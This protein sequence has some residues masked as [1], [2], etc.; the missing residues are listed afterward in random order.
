MS[1]R[2]VIGLAGGMCSGKDS[3]ADFFQQEFGYDHRSTSDVARAYIRDKDLGEPTRDLTREVATQLRATH[4]TEYLLRQ[5]I[6]AADSQRII[7]SGIY[8]V[9]EAMYLK[10]VGG[11]IV[12]I[13]ADDKLRF[14]R[15]AKRAR[16]GELPELE[17][18]RRLMDN[19]LNSQHTDQRLSDVM[20]LADFSI[21][22]SIPIR[23]RD[24]CLK[25]A[26]NVLT[27]IEKAR[28]DV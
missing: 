13:L 3:W 5:A 27:S 7:I 26:R 21:D 20:D 6:E 8:V 17:E 28:G 11:S 15:M 2:E 1:R 25:I 10:K 16:E 18:Y 23:D 4:G 14:E 12:S 22:G 19:D 9:P 24:Q